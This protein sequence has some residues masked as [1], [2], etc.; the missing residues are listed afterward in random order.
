MEI[1][2]LYASQALLQLEV[3][4][5]PATLFGVE[6]ET[7][8]YGFGQLWDVYGIPAVLVVLEKAR[9]VGRFVNRDRKSKQ[10]LF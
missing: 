5:N 2:S 10:R 7:T 9:R 8:A 6:C 1:K 3:E 4:P